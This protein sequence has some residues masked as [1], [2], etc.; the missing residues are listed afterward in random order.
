MSKISDDTICT[1]CG[2][3]YEKHFLDRDLDDVYCYEDTN[4]DFFTT[5][6]TPEMLLEMEVAGFREQL[7]EAQ[8]EIARLREELKEYEDACKAAA[9][10]SCDGNVKH[11]TCV[12]LLRHEVHAL[13]EENERLRKDAERYRY[14]RNGRRTTAIYEYVHAERL[15]KLDE[16]L[17]A[18]IDAAKETG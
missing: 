5:E 2:K 15:L 6:P 1:N 16:Q 17:D 11:C 14:I 12:G 4:G 10:E 7:K 8:A 3:P 9:E 13:Q 18:A